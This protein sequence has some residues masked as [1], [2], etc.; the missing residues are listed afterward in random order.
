VSITLRPEIKRFLQQTSPPLVATI[1]TVRSD[2][3]SHVVPVW[4]RLAEDAISV[5]TTDTRVWVRNL[6]RDPR[7]AVS[8]HEDE[9]PFQAV[10]LD[11]VANVVT[12]DA[13][14]VMQ[15]IHRITERYVDP[16]RVEAYVAEWPA[17]RTLVTIRP[18]V[19]RT[20]RVTAEA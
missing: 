2:G 13:D 3:H 1:A 15:E 6:L 18:T 14:A 17:L 4:Y 7:V 9:S 5:W 10:I 16:Q 20:A 11:G 19:I 12:A 8:V